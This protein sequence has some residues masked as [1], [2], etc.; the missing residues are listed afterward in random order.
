MNCSEKKDYHYIS[1]LLYRGTMHLYKKGK[2]TFIHHNNQSYHKVIDDWDA[3]TNRIQLYQHL[4]EEIKSWN[5]VVFHANEPLDPPIGS[6]EIW[7]AGVTYY[8]SREA[9]IEESKESG[10]AIFYDKVYDAKRPEIF[11]KGNALRAVGN[12]GQLNIRRD[13]VWNVPEP[14]FTLWLSSEGTVEGYVVGNDMSSRDI[15]GEN[16]LYLPQAK[17]Y[18]GCAGLGPG[19]YIP[20]SPISLSTGIRMSISRNGEEIFKGATSLEQIKR[21]FEELVDYLFRETSF[22]NGCFLMTGTGIIPPDEFTLAVDDV[23]E[24]EMDSIGKLKN[25]IGIRKEQA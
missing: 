22:P 9:R 13:A 11:Y 17:V 1:N 25:K 8:R 7:G 5:E 10:G 3:L 16:P 18:D 20:E 15:E 6:A 19:I 23:V 12:E 14:E 24:I 21:P 2:H 4:V